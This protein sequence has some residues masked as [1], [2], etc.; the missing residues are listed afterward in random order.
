MNSVSF[1]AEGHNLINK[2]MKQ[3]ATLRKAEVTTYIN[4][5]ILHCL[6]YSRIHFGTRKFTFMIEEIQLTKLHFPKNSKCRR[7]QKHLCIII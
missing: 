3:C 7:T 2:D 4:M 6:P 5:G 1:A